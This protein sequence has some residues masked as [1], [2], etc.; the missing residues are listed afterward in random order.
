M[1]QPSVAKRLRSLQRL[2]TRV[3]SARKIHGQETTNMPSHGPATCTSRHQCTRILPQVFFRRAQVR[4]SFAEQDII[5]R[6]AYLGTSPM[7][8]C[9]L[10]RSVSFG[11]IVPLTA[12]KRHVF[13]TPTLEGQGRVAQPSLLADHD[14]RKSKT[15]I[16]AV[17]SSVHSRLVPT[18]ILG[19]PMA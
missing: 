8:Q 18:P 17:A 16:V 14:L 19:G 1:K 7:S 5:R 13:P 12:G 10:T 3:S 11:E 9:R 2:G 6:E 4:R 15:E